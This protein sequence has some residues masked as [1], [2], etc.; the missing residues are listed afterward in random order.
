MTEAETINFGGWFV[1]QLVRRGW[2]PHQFA[3]TSGIVK[4]T[5]YKWT[6]NEQRPNP[7]HCVTIA[8]ALNVDLDLVL[9]AAGHRVHND[10]APGVVQ[11]ELGVLL[12]RIP[13]ALLIPLVPMLRGLIDTTIQDETK[14]RLTLRLVGQDGADA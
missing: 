2:S 8:Q 3:Q 6:H 13:E 12:N 9:A 1:A 14:L 4:S 10:S 11:A 5:V 7:K